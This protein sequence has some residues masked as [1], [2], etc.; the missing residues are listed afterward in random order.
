[1]DKS[2]VWNNGYWLSKYQMC[3]MKTHLSSYELK[4]MTSI[5]KRL[6]SNSKIQISKC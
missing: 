4:D 6:F 5:S 1:M 2:G 3:E